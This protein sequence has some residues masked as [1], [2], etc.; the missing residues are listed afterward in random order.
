MGR[1]GGYECGRVKGTDS[2]DLSEYLSSGPDMMTSPS[3]IGTERM[4]VITPAKVYSV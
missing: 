1:I 4:M 2:G 3:D